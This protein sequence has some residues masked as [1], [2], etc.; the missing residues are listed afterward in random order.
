MA[1]KSAVGPTD[2]E[3]WLARR[4]RRCHHSQL[5]LD[6]VV[7]ELMHEKKAAHGDYV[8]RDMLVDGRWAR[9]SGE[10]DAELLVRRLADI[11]DRLGDH[12]GIGPR[13]R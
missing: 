12:L 6:L 2:D 9:A 11:D 1:E 3:L 4:K 13:P 5:V 10:G 8:G 7:W